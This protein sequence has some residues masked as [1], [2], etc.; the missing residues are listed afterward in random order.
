MGKT[1][2]VP[3]VSLLLLMTLVVLAGTAWFAALHP[4]FVRR[5]IQGEEDVRDAAAS[6][7]HQR[8]RRSGLVV[9]MAA[10]LLLLLTDGM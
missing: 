5:M 10:I 3:P 8:I 1:A 7:E 2:Y 9:G 4:G 6:A